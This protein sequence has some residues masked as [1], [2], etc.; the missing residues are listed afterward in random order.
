MQLLR[1]AGLINCMCLAMFLL[2]GSIFGFAQ[3]V[4]FDTSGNVVVY[5]DVKVGLSEPRL[6][7]IYTKNQVTGEKM[8]RV[9]KVEPYPILMNAKPIID[10]KLAQ[11]P[12]FKSKFENP[13]QMILGTL[14]KEIEKLDD[15]LYTIAI[16]N[17]IIDESGNICYFWYDGIRTSKSAEGIKSTEIKDEIQQR[18]FERI[19]ELMAKAPGYVP[20]SKEG[21]PVIAN[22]NPS[23][24]WKQFKIEKHKLYEMNNYGQWL[25]LKQ[26]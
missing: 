11:S 7:T 24:F 13:R 8:M 6:D 22:I 21:K 14:Q 4:K 10:N 12:I 26:Q 1:S 5:R 19:Y 17:L 3:S 18:V 25:P 23:E 2:S 20:V 15:G 16:S 9:L